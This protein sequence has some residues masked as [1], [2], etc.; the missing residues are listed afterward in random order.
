[1]TNSRI[2]GCCSVITKPTFHR[3]HKLSAAFRNIQPQNGFSNLSPQCAFDIYVS[4]FSASHV[5][6][7]RAHARTLFTIDLLSCVGFAALC[8]GFAAKG[9]VITVLAS[10]LSSQTLVCEADGRWKSSW[11]R[12]ASAES[13]GL[14]RSQADLGC[15]GT[16]TE[17]KRTR[18]GWVTNVQRVALRTWKEHPSYMDHYQTSFCLVWNAFMMAINARNWLFL[19]NLFIKF[20]QDVFHNIKEL[21]NM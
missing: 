11:L 18:D 13:H 6:H 12:R 20:P 14:M 21:Y 19:L 1:M 5:V 7:Y 17:A 10:G 3:P 4:D 9:P 2:K 15:N 8:V 16:V